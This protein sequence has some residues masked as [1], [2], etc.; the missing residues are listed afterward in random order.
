MLHDEDHIDDLIGRDGRFQTSVRTY[1]LLR[2][3]GI[4]TVGQFMA[5]TECV[6]MSWRHSLDQTW[7]E[8]STIQGEVSDP[9]KR[10]AKGAGESQT[11]FTIRLLLW[12]AWW[13][14]HDT[15]CDRG[16]SCLLHENPYQEA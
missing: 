1:N 14:G 9:R 5:L 10:P 2:R 4:D 6:V 7:G 3:E 8:V 11:S 13:Q 12:E 16:W 15:S